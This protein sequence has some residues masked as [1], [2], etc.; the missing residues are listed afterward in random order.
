VAAPIKGVA[1]CP[2]EPILRETLINGQWEILWW[3]YISA[4]DK[5]EFVK[6]LTA[7]T[8]VRFDR[9]FRNPTIRQ[10]NCAFAAQ[11][12][13]DD[14]SW[15]VKVYS[16]G[17]NLLGTVSSQG[18]NYT[19]PEFAQTAG[20]PLVIVTADGLI[21]ADYRTSVTSTLPITGTYPHT[22]ALD[23]KTFRIAFTSEGGTLAVLDEYN[24]VVVTEQRCDRPEWA[25][26]GTAIYCRDAGGDLVVINYP[27]GSVRE[28]RKGFFATALDPDNSGRAV[29]TGGELV[30]VKNIKNEGA[31]ETE[32]NNVNGFGADWGD[33][34]VN[35]NE[36]A[37]ASFVVSTTEVVETVQPAVT[38]VV[39]N[40][41]CDYQ[42]TSLVECLR[43]A[44]ADFSFQ[45]RATLAAANNIADY[46]GTA[47]QNLALLAI[48]TQP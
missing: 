26:D 23:N 37:F 24:Q 27:D 31:L 34:Q 19:E 12:Q 2:Q 39:Q 17:M 3:N 21:K 16:F 14:G 4:T 42:G 8:D 38:P 43:L 29:V 47:E 33:R 9:N 10:D 48:L 35:P 44:K 7:G 6:N 36:D 22:L 32:L 28:I 20:D 25:P 15:N 11:V 45:A 1:K 46:H 13:A 5:V 40:P 18:K 41:H 30:F